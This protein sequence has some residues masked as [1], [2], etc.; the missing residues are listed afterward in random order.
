M[1][2]QKVILGETTEIEVFNTEHAARFFLKRHREP[3]KI[4]VRGKSYFQRVQTPQGLME[5][6]IWLNAT[7]RD[8][9]RHILK[10]ANDIA[11]AVEDELE[12][13]AEA[14]AASA[15]MNLDQ[16]KQ[17]VAGLSTPGHT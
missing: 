6:K 1:S 5:M 8:E 12:R 15:G 2:H 3:V 16:A 7:E 14:A 13:M 17:F 11:F 4:V 10:A 9:N